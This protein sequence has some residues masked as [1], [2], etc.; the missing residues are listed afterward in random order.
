MRREEFAEKING[1]LPANA[2]ETEQGSDVEKR[3]R[4]E[5]PPSRRLN[6][7]ASLRGRI[8][9]EFK[10]P[11]SCHK[12]EMAAQAADTKKKEIYTYEA[13]WQ[14]YGMNWSVRPDQK[15]RLAG[16]NNRSI[17]GRSNLYGNLSLHP[18]FVFSRYDYHSGKLY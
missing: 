18:S 16:T 5:V 14:I 13:P 7:G 1:D 11:P 12:N 17:C 6:V 3:R 9:N 10:N 8:Q 15:F 4:R 2:F